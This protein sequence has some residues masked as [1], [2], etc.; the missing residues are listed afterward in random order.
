M[1]STLRRELVL[2]QNLHSR[3]AT[4]VRARGRDSVSIYSLGHANLKD[5][6]LLERLAGHYK[7]ESWVL[8]TADDRMPADHG[9]L[10]ER[11]GTTVATIDPTHDEEHTVDQWRRDVVQRWANAIQAQEQGTVRRYSLGWHRPWTRRRRRSKRRSR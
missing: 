5:P 10:I 7:P 9:A 1:T 6:E 4:E 2:D 11:L 3:L 8:V